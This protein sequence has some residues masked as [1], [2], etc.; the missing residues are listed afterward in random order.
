MNR[1]ILVALF[2][3][4]IS[5]AQGAQKKP[6]VL[7]IVADQWRAQSFGYAGDPNVYTPNLDRLARCSVNL[8]NTVS[9]CPVCSPFRGS[10]LTGQRPL[11]HGVFVND[12]P[13]NTNA[14]TFAK[15]LKQSG[16]DTGAIGKWHIDGHGRDAFIP[17]ERRQGFDYWKV[18]ECTHEY[19]DS[20]YY[21]D[22]PEKLTWKGYDAFA[23]TEDA[24]N[25][26]KKHT[27]GPK[28]FLLLLAWG[29]PHS[30]YHTAPEEF[31]KMYRP[32][33]IKLR[34]N[35]PAESAQKARADLAGYYAH[36]TALDR[37]V[38][39]LW[40][41]LKDAGLEQDT[42]VVFTSDHGDMHGS[43]GNIKKQRP[44]DEAIRTPLL[45]HYPA[46]FGQAEKD[47]GALINSE[48]LM[49]TILGLCKVNIPKSVEGFDYSNYLLG[50]KV[51]IPDAALLTCVVPFGEWT[52]KIG[53]REYRGM[54]TA[55]Y[56]YVRDLKGPWL[57][58]DN[59]RDPYQMTNLCNRAEAKTIQAELDT[60]LQKR[61]QQNGDKFLP[62]QSY[63][64]RWNY[65]LLPK[66][67]T[68]LR[69]P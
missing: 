27:N 25:Y 26:I 46:A 37:C 60:Q 55:R 20:T 42:I 58:Y 32:A 4:L 18:R 53:G 22:T 9:G 65:L 15:V 14:V 8:T 57:L 43:Q 11:T 66:G 7:I 49:P 16:Y 5:F 29:P 67:S 68:R 63:L 17:R 12:V 28:P 6:N 10:L 40:Q 13:L 64:D 38:G 1:V 24:K 69:E 56:T 62:A 30:P 36:C 3:S 23:Q 52:P 41:T 39:E 35:V 50:N 2:A 33:D 19:N 59:Q 44:W 45:I 47:F 48:D 34:A 21:G 54:R 31:R 61:L 51:K